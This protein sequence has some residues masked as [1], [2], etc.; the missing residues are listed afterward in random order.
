MILDKTLTL[1]ENQ[2]ITA[3]AISENV[4]NWP[5]VDVVPLETGAIHRNLGAG[6]EVPVLM[7]VTEDFAGLTSLTIELVTAQNAAL[8]T[9]DV[10]LYTTPAIAVADLVAG[11]RTSMRWLP[12]TRMLRYFGARFTVG[13]ANATAGRVTVAIATEVNT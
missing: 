3:T 6:E 4:I 12:D 2:A 9:G 13:G 1:A 11:Y 10:V 7:Q 5:D 8:T